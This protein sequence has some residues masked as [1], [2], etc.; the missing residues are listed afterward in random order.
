MHRKGEHAF[1]EHA[2]TPWSSISDS[3]SGTRV[4]NSIGA[5][6]VSMSLSSCCDV[7]CHAPSPQSFVL[8]LA[9]ALGRLLPVVAG[10]STLPA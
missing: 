8:L 10:G 5:L 6:S 2:L 7:A 9:L 3:Y 4:L 1:T